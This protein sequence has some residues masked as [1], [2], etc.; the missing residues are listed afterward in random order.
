MVDSETLARLDVFPEDGPTGD[1]NMSEALWNFQHFNVREYVFRILSLKTK[2]TSA[3][4]WLFDFVSY[5]L[6]RYK[7]EKY[8]YSCFLKSF[9]WSTHIL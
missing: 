4:R 1:R 7:N 3:S 2:D 9:L 6:A 8:F 5:F